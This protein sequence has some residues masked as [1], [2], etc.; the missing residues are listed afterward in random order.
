MELKTHDLK[1][2]DLFQIGDRPEKFIFLKRVGSQAG[3]F[4]SCR[5]ILDDGKGKQGLR[6]VPFYMLEA[7]IPKIQQKGGEKK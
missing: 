2:S 6:S 4:V 1:K 3:E 5:V 7:E